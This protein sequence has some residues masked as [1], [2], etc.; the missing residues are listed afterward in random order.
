MLH[1]LEG[2]Y[3]SVRKASYPQFY[4]LATPGAVSKPAKATLQMTNKDQKVKKY[5]NM[6]SLIHPWLQYLSIDFKVRPD[7]L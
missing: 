5:G 4:A 2:G 7:A 6:F 1:S 3:G